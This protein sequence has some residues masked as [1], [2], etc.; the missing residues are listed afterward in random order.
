MNQ[1]KD[2]LKIVEIFH[3]LFYLPLSYPLSDLMV[4]LKI[5]AYILTVEPR[6]PISKEAEQILLLKNCFSLFQP[7]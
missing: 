1:E 4:I 3:G 6:F 7:F 2:N 5:A